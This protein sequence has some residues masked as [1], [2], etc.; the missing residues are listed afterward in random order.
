PKL[1]KLSRLERNEMMR[2]VLVDR[3]SF[4]AHRDIRELP[5]FELIAAKGGPKLK[6]AVPGDTYPNG[7]KDDQ[8]QSSPGTMRVG[9]GS[10]D[11]QAVPMTSLIEILMGLSGRTVVDKTGLVGKYDLRLRWRPED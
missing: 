8:G 9:F 5:V 1:N 6:E 11:C 3:F 4:A 10:V 2:S 7:L